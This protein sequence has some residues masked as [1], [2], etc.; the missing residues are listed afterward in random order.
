MSSIHFR[1]PLFTENEFDC[2]VC[3]CGP[4]TQE[5]EEM[6]GISSKLLSGFGSPAAP[7]R[8]VVPDARRLGRSQTYA[9]HVETVDLFAT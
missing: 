9:N 7:E 1:R 2:V 6:V 5:T 4:S 8:C 3:T